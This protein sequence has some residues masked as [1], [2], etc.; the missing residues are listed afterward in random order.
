M[1][2]LRFLL[3]ALLAAV[4]L[5]AA[6]AQTYYDNVVIVLDASGSMKSPMP[7]AGTSKMES[8]KTA[9][10]SV[11]AKLP[12]TTRVGLLVFSAAN[13]K[14]PWVFPLGPRNDAV[15]IPAIDQLQPY[16]DTPLGRYLKIAADRLLEE[17]A[18]QFGY[19][20]YRMLVITDGEAQDQDLVER[21]TPEI[22]ARGITLDVI[23]V[24]MRDK[25]TLATK[26]HSYRHATDSESLNRALREVFAEVTAGAKDMAQSE[27]FAAL[28]PIPVEAAAAAIQALSRSGNQP[29]GVKAQAAGAKPQ[30]PAVTTAP[31][32]PKP[33]AAAAPQPRPQTRAPAPPPPPARSH[34][35]QFSFAGLLVVAVLGLALARVV[36]K[37]F[38]S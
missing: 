24:A 36:F 23:G 18:R 12:P 6:R 15:L 7:G 1:K 11:L 19:G 17:R 33:Q 9:L 4:L 25:H 27:A 13:L 14:N 28:A 38:R 34:G 31:T 5:P 37:A 2:T 20:S 21:H 3:V 10:K 30:S 22:M 35:G 32:A 8:A 16:A 26:A 29:I